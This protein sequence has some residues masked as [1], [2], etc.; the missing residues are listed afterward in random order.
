MSIDLLQLV[1]RFRSFEDRETE[2]AWFRTLVPWIAPEAYLNI[3]FKPAPRGILLEMARKLS[4]PPSVHEFFQR[5][6]GAILFS[7][8]LSVFGVV[9][10]GR[11]LNRQDPF[12][13]PPFNIEQE[14]ASWPVH[15]DQFL[16]IGAYQ[17]DGS[18]VCINRSDA[19]VH[20]LKK[21]Q[22]APS[23]SWPSLESWL[24][25]EIARLSFAFDNEGRMTV[26]ESETGPPQSA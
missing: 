20:V 23:I 5:Q 16:V 21:K 9:E 10:P 15:R 11:L 7:G 26:P 18:R 19:T 1:S 13:L 14:N 4:F 8:A 6:N 25:D 24:G 2:V 17:F 3:I 12:S 22:K